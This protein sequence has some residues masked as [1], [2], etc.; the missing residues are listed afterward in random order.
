MIISIL[1][2]INNKM[3]VISLQFCYL[4]ATFIY[5]YVNSTTKYFGL[6]PVTYVMTQFFM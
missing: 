2:I 6:T 3:Q 5:A 4:F 1:Y